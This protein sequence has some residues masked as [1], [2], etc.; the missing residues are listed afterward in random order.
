MLLL[1]KTDVDRRMLLFFGVSIGVF[2]CKAI[3]TCTSSVLSFRFPRVIIVEL[4][5][6]QSFLVVLEKE[7]KKLD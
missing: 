5:V 1:F 7:F 6:E 3:Y 4:F 2:S